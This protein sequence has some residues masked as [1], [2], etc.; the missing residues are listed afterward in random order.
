M[1][2][3]GLRSH[4]SSCAKKGHFCKTKPLSPRAGGKLHGNLAG[5]SLSHR[6]SKNSK[7]MDKGRHLVDW[8]SHIFLDSPRFIDQR[9]I[10][11]HWMHRAVGVRRIAGNPLRQGHQ[12]FLPHVVSSDGC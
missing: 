6:D 2:S 7:V 8:V 5:G 1:L 11:A 9:G 12:D 3:K 4:A 10:W